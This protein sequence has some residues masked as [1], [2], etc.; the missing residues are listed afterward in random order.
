MSPIPEKSKSK[1]TFDGTPNMS[2]PVMA[3]SKKAVE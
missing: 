2:S 3:D 1:K